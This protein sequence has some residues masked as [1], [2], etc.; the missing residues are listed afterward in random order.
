MACSPKQQRCVNKTARAVPARTRSCHDSSV[1][2][3]IRSR[4]CTNSHWWWPVL[5]VH[6]SKA[7]CSTVTRYPTSC[8]H[9][10]PPTPHPSTPRHPCTCTGL[11]PPKPLTAP[12]NRHVL[13]KPTSCCTGIHAEGRNPSRPCSSHRG[14]PHR[15]ANIRW[16][17]CTGDGIF[18]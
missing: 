11:L 5:E 10:L 18:C 8:T 16:R 12:C 15:Q 7:T 6:I 4:G 2:S 13:A 1:D 3:A 9:M 14:I 17:H